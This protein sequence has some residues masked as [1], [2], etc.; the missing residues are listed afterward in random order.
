M[1]KQK[2]SD[3]SQR[4]IEAAREA[5][6]SEDEAVF[7]ENLRQLVNAPKMEPTMDEQIIYHVKGKRG[8]N[9]PVPLDSLTAK[10]LEAHQVEVTAALQRQYEVIASLNPESSRSKKIAGL[11]RWASGEAGKYPEYEEALRALV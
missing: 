9:I 2:T 3:Q 6:C 8:A 7:D 1:K 10:V 5:G 4:F 11:Q